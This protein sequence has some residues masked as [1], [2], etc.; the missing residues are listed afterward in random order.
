VQYLIEEAVFERVTI[1]EARQR[2][3]DLGTTNVEP[4]PMA[5]ARAFAEGR[6]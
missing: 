1:E 3:E 4:D 5:D 6:V 2:A